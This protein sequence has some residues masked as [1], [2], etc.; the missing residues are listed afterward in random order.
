MESEKDE[1]SQNALGALEGGP[2]EGGSYPGT[3]LGEISSPGAIQEV[4][5]GV[6][7]WGVPQLVERA[8]ETLG[9]ELPERGEELFEYSTPIRPKWRPDAVRAERKLKAR[10]KYLA[11]KHRKRG[12][13]YTTGRTHWQ[14]KLR[15]KKLNWNKYHLNTGSCPWKK[16]KLSWE[17]HKVAVALS[18]DEFLDWMDSLEGGPSNV[19]RI[20]VWDKVAKIDNFLVID[21][22]HKVLYRGTNVPE[23][24]SAFGR[25]KKSSAPE[26]SVG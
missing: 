23:S 20:R 12:R 5:E 9:L 11:K 2:L 19:K 21:W 18:Q 22:D 15:Q 14:R 17:I 1:N 7:D 16:W 24:L 25:A 8:S 13:P 10:A 3:T 4:L 6:Y 26:G